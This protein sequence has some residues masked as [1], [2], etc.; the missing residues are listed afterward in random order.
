[1]SGAHKITARRYSIT[2]R[3]NITAMFDLYAK[4][5][6]LIEAIRKN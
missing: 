3:A 4:A 2:A 1:M 6:R 5:G